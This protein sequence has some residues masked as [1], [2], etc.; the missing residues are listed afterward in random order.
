MTKTPVSSLIACVLAIISLF[1]YNNGVIEDNIGPD[2]DNYQKMK[3]HEPVDHFFLQRSWPDLKPDIRAFDQALVSIKNNEANRV[4]FIPGFDHSWQLEGPS[5]IGGRIN[6]VLIHPTNTQIIYVGCAT[7]GIFKTTDGGSS[8][9][10][11]FDDQSFLP[12]GCLVFEPGNP[13]TIYAGTGDPNISGFPF[14]GDGVWKS[15]DDGSTWT[16]LGLTDQRIVSR[17]AINPTNTL[18]IYVATMGIP[19]E[20][21]ND[22][23]LYKSADGGATWSQVLF[24]SDDAGVIDMVMDPSNPLV[25]YAAG[26]NRIRNNEES[27]GIGPAAKVYKTID[28]GATWTILANGLPSIDMSRIGLAISQSNPNTLYAAYVDDSYSFHGIYKTTDGGLN[29]NLLPSNGID[30]WFMGGFGWYFG[31]IVVD[32]SNE[33]H[34]Y[35]CGVTLFSTIDGGQNWIAADPSGDTHADKHDVWFVNSNT[36]VLATDGGLYR[37]DNAGGSWFDIEDIPNNQFYR[38]VHDPHNPGVITGGLQDN[39]TVTGNSTGLNSWNKIFGADGF[40]PIYDPTNSDNIF[41]EIQNG[42]IY[43][44]DNGGAFFS[45]ATDGIDNSDRTNWDTPYIM[46]AHNSSVLYTGTYRIYKNLTGTNALWNPISPDLTDG[47]IFSPRFHTITTIDE[48]SVLQGVLYAGT[49]DGN[50]WYSPN[51]GSTWNDISLG[52]PDRYVTSV[53]A[54]SSPL[55]ANTVYVTVSG[56]KYNEQIPHVFRSDDNGTT[57]ISISGD[58]PQVAVND[59]YI[60]QSSNG[61]VIFVATDGGVY[62]TLDGGFHWDRIGDNMPILP[63]FD[64]DVDPAVNTLIAGTHGRSA[65]T[66]PIDSILISVGIGDELTEGTID[67]WPLLANDILNFQLGNSRNGTIKVFSV[68]GQQVLFRNLANESTGVLD[69]SRLDAGT[70]IVNYRSNKV[71]KSIKFLK[72]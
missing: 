43:A 10:P 68:S 45:S 65:M 59:I 20:R 56:Y 48:S 64:I 29:W 50:V 17:I 52:L 6:T 30:P 31:R 24:I 35:I 1:L 70:Y 11:I 5:N 33:D 58:L 57:W 42:G 16:H 22:R 18:E 7:G 53:A 37:T 36:Q 15:T 12:I 51:D 62:G 21:N 38:I 13:S 14:I 28:G 71:D 72:Y 19:F 34:V 47:I 46:S 69:L 60:H 27:L 63:V 40:Q 25:I 41:V 67:F 39:G 32:P 2:K 4:T 44:S 55:N 26:W 54:S 9:L 61:Q 49:S 23:G 8:W 66:Y 3:K